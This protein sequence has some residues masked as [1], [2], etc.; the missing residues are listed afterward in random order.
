MPESRLCLSVSVASHGR[1]VAQAVGNV[2][3]YVVCY[4]VL[5]VEEIPSSDV[6]SGQ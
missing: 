6:L 5:T 3:L 2:L 1:G 4:G